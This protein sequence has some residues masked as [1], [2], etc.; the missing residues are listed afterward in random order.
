MVEFSLIQSFGS[1]SWLSPNICQEL[2]SQMSNDRKGDDTAV[3]FC[4]N[5]VFVDSQWGYTQASS[6]ES[7]RREE[8]HDTAEPLALAWPGTISQKLGP[9]IFVVLNKHNSGLITAEQLQF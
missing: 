4:H 6:P 5:I 3:N 8:L 7:P 2:S 1:G 9:K